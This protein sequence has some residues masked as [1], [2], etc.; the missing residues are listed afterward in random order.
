MEKLEAS[1]PEVG[2]Y[3]YLLVV[4]PGSPVN[5]K[6]KKEKESLTKSYHE[7]ITVKTQPHITVANFLAREPMEETVIRYMERIF[8]MQRSFEVAFNNYSG[9]PP[10]TIYLRIQNPEPFKQINTELKVIS[11]Y[12]SSCSCPPVRLVSN[13]H[14]TIARRLPETDYLKAMMEYS[15]K[16][17]HEKFIVS[18]LVLLR[19][20]SQY[21]E[22]KKVHVFR[23]QPGI[24]LLSTP[25]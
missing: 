2:L 12:V 3:E 24:N 14:L 18:E 7:K 15:Q 10:H 5:E 21:D 25:Y 1:P 16:T 8:S 23:L 6:I 19:R 11:N 4:Q 13:P 17:F 20:S 22:C 9:V